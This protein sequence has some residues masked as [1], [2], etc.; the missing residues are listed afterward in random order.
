[1]VS[2]LADAHANSLG[3]GW[4]IHRAAV[5]ADQTEAHSVASCWRRTARDQ[6]RTVQVRTKECDMKAHGALITVHVVIERSR[7]EGEE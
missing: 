5:C 4:T 2:F 1:M 3:S 7:T 6:G